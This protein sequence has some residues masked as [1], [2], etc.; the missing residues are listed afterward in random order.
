M[1]ETTILAEP[2][3]ATI[4]PS[5]ND[6]RAQCGICGCSTAV[7]DVAVRFRFDT[8]EWPVCTSCIYVGTANI[9]KRLD[10]RADY[11]AERASYL[12]R[13]AKCGIE[14]PTVAEVARAKGELCLKAAEQAA[15][16]VDIGFAHRVRLH[17]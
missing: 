8:D 12:R 15:K 2:V 9:S 3:K 16:L 11:L 6:T 7:D 10:D 5:F 17:D 14:L 13:L 1:S 4:K